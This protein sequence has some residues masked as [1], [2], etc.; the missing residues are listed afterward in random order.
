ML[1]FFY[2]V[3]LNHASVRCDYV[4]LINMKKLNKSNNIRFI[5]ISRDLFVPTEHSSRCRKFENASGDANARV[6][7]D[8]DTGVLV[9]DVDG[10]H[11][12]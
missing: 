5:K 7:S 1:Y 6:S 2:V 4:M 11:H 10:F 3:M 9:E 12:A 8:K